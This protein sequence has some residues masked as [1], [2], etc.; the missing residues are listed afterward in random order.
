GSDWAKNCTVAAIR[1]SDSSRILSLAI[2]LIFSVPIV[3]LRLRER[4]TPSCYVGAMARSC[5]VTGVMSFFSHWSGGKI[6]RR[7]RSR[8]QETQACRRK[9]R[10]KQ[11]V[12]AD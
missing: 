8:T 2:L 10:I 7:T 9:N 12:A 5:K 4:E 6:R 3:Q 11:K 1:N